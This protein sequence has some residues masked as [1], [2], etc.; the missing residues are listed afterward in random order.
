MVDQLGI[1]YLDQVKDTIDPYLHLW[2]A[3]MAIIRRL[4]IYKRCRVTWLSSHLKAYA[5]TIAQTNQV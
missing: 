2:R 5:Y 4:S 1:E 3:H